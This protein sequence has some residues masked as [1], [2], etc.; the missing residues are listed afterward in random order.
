[1][2]SENAVLVTIFYCGCSNRESVFF[3][4][5]ALLTISYLM[6]GCSTLLAEIPVETGSAGVVTQRI[7]TIIRTTSECHRH[8]CSKSIFRAAFLPGFILGVW[9]NLY[10]CLRNESVEVLEEVKSLRTW[11][12]VLCC[13]VQGLHK[14]KQELEESLGEEKRWFSLA[15][16]FLI[17]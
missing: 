16:V 5:V 8:E 4:C 6:D 9:I 15:R 2:S 11:M 17:T 10:S 12:W 14:Q 7:V 3:S 1:M 13:R